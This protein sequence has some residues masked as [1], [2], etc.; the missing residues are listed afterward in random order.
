ME[1]DKPIQCLKPPKSQD[2]FN[3]KSPIPGEVQKGVPRRDGEAPVQALQWCECW[4]FQ[5]AHSKKN[6]RIFT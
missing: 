4:F 6:I 3:D 5:K 1:N 2:M